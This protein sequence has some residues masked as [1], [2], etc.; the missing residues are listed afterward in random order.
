MNPELF[1]DAELF[2]DV[3][4]APRAVSAASALSRSDH[5]PNGTEVLDL[6]LVEARN[7]TLGHVRAGRG[8]DCQP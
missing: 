3:E 5:V 8:L 4:P 2:A 1:A 7:T 6:E